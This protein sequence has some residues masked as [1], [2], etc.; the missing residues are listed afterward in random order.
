MI[1]VQAHGHT[2]SSVHERL[3]TPLVQ[4]THTLAYLLKEGM[5][6]YQTIYRVLKLTEFTQAVYFTG[7]AKFRGYFTNNGIGYVNFLQEYLLIDNALRSE[8]PAIIQSLAYIT[9]I[10][11]VGS[12]SIYLILMFFV[13]PSSPTRG[14][15]QV[16]LRYLTIFLVVFRT[17]LVIPFCQLAYIGLACSDSIPEY[18]SRP[19][20]SDI[21]TELLEG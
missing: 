20:Y 11:C 5:R 6:N 12:V 4:R 16:L 14:L 7:N 8:N 18:R 1:D 13:D 3:F 17:V 2:A 9:F 21:R 15:K 10:I 19:V